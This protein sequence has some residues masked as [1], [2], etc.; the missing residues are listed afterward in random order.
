MNGILPF[1]FLDSIVKAITE[2]GYYL[3]INYSL[4]FINNCTNLGNAQRFAS[5]KFPHKCLTKVFALLRCFLRSLS[6][7]QLWLHN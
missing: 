4:F 2:L 1:S 5:K 6:H 7:Y 3:Y